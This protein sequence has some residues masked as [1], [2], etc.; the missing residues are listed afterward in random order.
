M[1]GCRGVESFNFVL[2]CSC[3]EDEAR[4]SRIEGLLVFFCPTFIKLLIILR[5]LLFTDFSSISILIG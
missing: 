5:T 2:L 3:V 4:L 1:G